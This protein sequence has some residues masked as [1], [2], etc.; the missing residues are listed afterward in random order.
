MQKNAISGVC[1]K[2]RIQINNNPKNHPF[3]LFSRLDTKTCYR[4]LEHQCFQGFSALQIL[5]F[6]FSLFLKGFHQICFVFVQHPGVT[7]ASGEPASDA[8][9]AFGG[10][11]RGTAF[12]TSHNGLSATDAGETA[13]DPVGAESS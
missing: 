3:K 11:R 6:S 2:N 13:G 10:S 7:D 12:A 5:M 8:A 1:E 9:A 4:S